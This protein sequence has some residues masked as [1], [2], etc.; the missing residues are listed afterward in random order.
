MPRFQVRVV[1]S[2]SITIE[3]DAAHVSEA[4]TKA[5]REA[6]AV[7]GPEYECETRW[8][9][10]VQRGEPWVDVDWYDLHPPSD[11]VHCQRSAGN[12][13][14]TAECELLCDRLRALGLEV[15]TTWNGAPCGSLSV[16]CRGRQPSPFAG[17]QEPFTKEQRAFLCAPR[18]ENL[19]SR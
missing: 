6:R 17:Q 12:R 11:V 1:V 15:V 7:A 10:I 13:F 14:T 19:E 4:A 9:H 16:Q 18:P 3:V 2:R 5:C 8:E